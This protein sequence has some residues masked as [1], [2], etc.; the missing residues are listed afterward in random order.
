ML[1][2]PSLINCR[3]LLGYMTKTHSSYYDIIMSQRQIYYHF[4]IG[5]QAFI[6]WP[7]LLLPK[8]HNFFYI[9]DQNHV[10]WGM[11]IVYWKCFYCFFSDK[12][13][14][15]FGNET[16]TVPYFHSFWQSFPKVVW[17]DKEILYPQNRRGN[18]CDT[19]HIMTSSMII[20]DVL[21][22]GIEKEHTYVHNSDKQMYHFFSFFTINN[23]TKLHSSWE[24]K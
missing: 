11:W 5:L 2:S 24:M 6:I 18:W 8:V 1:Y 16:C 9:P 19:Q 15:N 13:Y 7:W 4:V 10:L 20:I 12:I 22:K 14:L 23:K 17:S 3:K 21:V